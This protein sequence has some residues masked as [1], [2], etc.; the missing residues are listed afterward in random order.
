MLRVDAVRC[1]RVGGLGEA[2][3]ADGAPRPSRR[4][5]DIGRSGSRPL[6]PAVCRRLDLRSAAGAADRRL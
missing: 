6:A 2:Q 5:S 4:R 1:T 3:G